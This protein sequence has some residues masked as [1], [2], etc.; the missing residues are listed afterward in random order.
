M[1][2]LL[3]APLQNSVSECGECLML[4]F[5]QCYESTGLVSARYTPIGIALIESNCP[6]NGFHVYPRERRRFTGTA[7]SGH[8]RSRRQNRTIHY[9]AFLVWR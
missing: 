8:H 7:L 9:R 3:L 5:F 1:L 4:R 2:V 6:E